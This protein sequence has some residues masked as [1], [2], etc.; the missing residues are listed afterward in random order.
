MQIAL[1]GRMASQLGATGWQSLEDMNQAIDADHVGQRRTVGC[2]PI[3]VA[4]IGDVRRAMSERN[5]EALSE[6]N[7]NGADW[8]PQMDVLV[9]VEMTGSMA[10]EAIEHAELAEDFIS[11]CGLI[12]QWDYA[13]KRNPL[14]GTEYLFTQVDMQ[15]NA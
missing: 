5:S 4:A 9:R 14:S 3:E 6:F 13:I 8:F 11:N 7:E 2:L 10:D 1:R 12:L 15:P